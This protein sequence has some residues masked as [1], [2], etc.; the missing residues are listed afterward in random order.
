MAP[1][2]IILY[3]LLLVGAMAIMGFTSCVTEHEP[4]N[5]GVSE[6]DPLPQFS[7]TLN[8]G[9]TVSRASLRGKMVLIELFNTGCPDCRRS[10]PIV[11]ELYEN[12]KDIQGIEI[13]AI[14]RSE[15]D[16]E[17]EN[18]WRENGF[19]LPYSPQSDRYVYDLFASTGIPRI[20]IADAQGIIIAS[21]GPEDHPSL[22]QLTNLL[23]P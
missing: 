3:I 13:M 19:T 11:N 18:Y 23:R 9:R 5:S 8:D 16:P 6:G 22:S 12:M 1:D 21:F 20:Y 2:K 15:E 10:L 14:A 17:L 4:K 7:V